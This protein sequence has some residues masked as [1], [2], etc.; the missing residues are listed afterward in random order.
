MNTPR[1]AKGS[2]QPPV[3]LA[4]INSTDSTTGYLMFAGAAAGERKITFTSHAER[5]RLL[6]ELMLARVPFA[7]GGM[8]PGPA[9]EVALLIASAALAGPYLELSWTGPQQWVVRQMTNSADQWQLE[10]DVS[11]IANTSFDPVSLTSFVGNADTPA[12]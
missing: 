10:P 11:E 2:G 8:C 12:R 1:Y 7:V 4:S 9:D 3:H 5:V 6:N